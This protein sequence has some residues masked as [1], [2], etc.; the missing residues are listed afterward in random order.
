MAAPSR[1]ENINGMDLVSGSHINGR[2]N[3][4]VNCVAG[5]H[6]EQRPSPHQLARR[7]FSSF[8][9][10]NLLIYTDVLSLRRAALA[11]RGLEGV[12]AVL[13]NV[14]YAKKFKVRSL[15][16]LNLHSST[17]SLSKPQDNSILKKIVKQY[18]KLLNERP[19]L[20][21]SCTR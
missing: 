9:V 13:Y 18:L 7:L 5:A 20:T 11:A 6:E 15:S 1:F 19:V 17:M 12:V 8:T 4:N 21:K 2:V 14:L 3:L 10:T 16:E